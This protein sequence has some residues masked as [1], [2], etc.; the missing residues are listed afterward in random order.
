MMVS[1]Q[2]AGRGLVAP[3]GV[4]IT[5]SGQHPTICDFFDVQV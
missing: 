1:I 3:F 4:S 5:D 2:M